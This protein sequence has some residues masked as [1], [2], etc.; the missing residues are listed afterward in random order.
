[1]HGFFIT[2]SIICKG[3]A[4]LLCSLLLLILLG[5]SPAGENFGQNSGLKEKP[6]AKEEKNMS[7]K[8]LVKPQIPFIDQH[9]AENLE[10]ATFALG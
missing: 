4:L 7:Q 1:M 8:D 10:T 9:T 5:C 2:R 6:L 3:T